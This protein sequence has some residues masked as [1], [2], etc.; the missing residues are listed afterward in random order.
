MGGGVIRGE[1]NETVKH[2]DQAT[3]IF[4][5]YILKSRFD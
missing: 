1:M 4:L 5:R 3:I 2:Y